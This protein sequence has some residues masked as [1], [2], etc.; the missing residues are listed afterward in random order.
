MSD[1]E[2]GVAPPASAAQMFEKRTG[3]Y[4]Q[5]RD[6]IKELQEKHET[7][8]KPLLE[9]QNLLTAWFMNQLEQVGAQSVKTSK[10]TVYA[11]TRYTASLAD[12]KAFM[13]YVITNQ[14]W[15]LLDRKANSTACKDFVAEHG[16]QPPGVNLSAIR[17]VGVRRK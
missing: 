4:V 17:T 7:E 10:G 11:T 8:L 3:Q 2:E 16:S 6:R 14:K 15:E 9:T 12:P 13:D 5:L 1:P